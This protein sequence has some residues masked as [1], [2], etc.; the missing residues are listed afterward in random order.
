MVFPI[1]DRLLVAIGG[2]ATHPED[3]E[4][5]SN[6]QKAIAARTATSLLPLLLQDN[7]LIHHARQWSG[8]W[9]D[10]HAPGA[11]ARSHRA[12]AARYL[13][14]PQ[15]GRYRLPARAGTGERAAQGR[16]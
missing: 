16:Q 5:T 4:G 11:Y 10:T 3:I 12:D 6:E 7:E 1:P 14:R 9:Q 15:P 8:G 2:N 13:R